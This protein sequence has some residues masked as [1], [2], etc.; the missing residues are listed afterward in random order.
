MTG[1]VADTNYKSL[2]NVTDTLQSFI[3]NEYDAVDNP[4]GV[5]LDTSNM[6]LIYTDVNNKT[7]T[8]YYK[9][10]GG[11]KTEK[12]SG[13]ENDKVQSVT[14]K[15]VCVKRSVNLQDQQQEPM[16]SLSLRTLFSRSLSTMF[17]L[18]QAVYQT[19]HCMSMR[20]LQIW[21]LKLA[22]TMII[23]QQMRR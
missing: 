21:V 8:Q 2:K 19:I 4:D 1:F 18:I 14:F 5:R 11:I 17:H 15:N 23:R 13:Y 12:Q 6:K 9:N 10:N 22:R 16:S 3:S 7:T 20:Y